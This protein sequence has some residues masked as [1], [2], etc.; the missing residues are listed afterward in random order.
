MDLI[1][2][3]CAIKPWGYK[4]REEAHTCAL[5]NAKVNAWIMG[6][7]IVVVLLLMYF[8]GSS[9]ATIVLLAVLAGRAIYAGI[10]WKKYYVG[11]QF[12]IFDSRRQA[13]MKQGRSEGDAFALVAQEAEA[14][15]AT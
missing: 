6:I 1:Y 3:E 5:R 9:A 11:Q 14:D 10:E 12:T 15:A 13:Y 8:G 2:P 7:V 4:S